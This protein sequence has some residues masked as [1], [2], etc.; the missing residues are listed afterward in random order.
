MRLGAR[1]PGHQLQKETAVLCLPKLSHGAAR[2]SIPCATT[3]TGAVLSVP[4][5]AAAPGIGPLTPPPTVAAPGVLRPRPRR[6]S[7]AHLDRACAS[8]RPSA[9]QDSPPRPRVGHSTRPK[10][11]PR[12]FFHL[13]VQYAL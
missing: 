10:Q 12:P 5:P 3:S 7:L 6:P 4:A 13:R 11:L 8:L 2:G 9:V 1:L